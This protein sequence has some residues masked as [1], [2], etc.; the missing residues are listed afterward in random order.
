[1]E[2]DTFDRLVHLERLSQDAKW[3]EQNHTVQKWY[4]I[5]GEEV[6][7]VAKAILEHDSSQLGK[8]LVQVAAVCKAVYE[9]GKRNLWL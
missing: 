5:L 9:S 6:G 8:E 1:M 4:M 3:G 7:E 2:K